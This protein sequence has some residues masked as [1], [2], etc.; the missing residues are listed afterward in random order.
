MWQPAHVAPISPTFAV[1]RPCPSG[2]VRLP[3]S[4]TVLSHACCPGTDLPA[5]AVVSFAS[6]SSES[7]LT[8]ITEQ[9]ELASVCA[10]LPRTGSG[11]GSGTGSSTGSGSGPGPGASGEQPCNAALHAYSLTKEARRA[12]SSSL[13]RRAMVAA[14]RLRCSCSAAS[15]RDNA[16]TRCS[17]PG[18]RATCCPSCFHCAE[19]GRNRRHVLERRQA[20]ANMVR[21]ELQTCTLGRGQACVR[22]R[23]RDPGGLVQERS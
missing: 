8:V 15:A 14:W 4:S 19:V 17:S 6:S 10:A 11:P 13:S 9:S 23:T 12:A 5:L 7:L 1:I 21:L 2:Q 16:C 18:G 22:A 20:R 3:S